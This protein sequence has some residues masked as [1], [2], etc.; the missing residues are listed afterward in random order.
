M[1]IKFLLFAEKYQ[2]LEKKRK[3]KTYIILI[4]KI[5]KKDKYDK[6]KGRCM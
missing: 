3:E 5:P 4:L 2:L 1:I 6:G